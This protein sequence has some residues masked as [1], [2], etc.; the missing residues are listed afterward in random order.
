MSPKEANRR[1]LRR[2]FPSMGVY[3][4]LLLGSNRIQHWYQP[5]GA[6]LFALAILPALPILAVIWALGMAVIEQPDEYI[7]LKLVKS[8]LI[9]TAILL[10][11]TTVWSFL[12]DA[13]VVPPKPIHLAFPLWC[14]GM[15][16]GQCFIWMQERAAGTGE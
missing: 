14:A 6:A 15:F 7:R 11:V 8:M 5:T 4:V 1:Y 13:G 9:G 10:A 12:E 3:V 2:F 16:L